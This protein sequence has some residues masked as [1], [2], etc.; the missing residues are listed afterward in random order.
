MS[1]YLN[2]GISTSIAIWIIVILVVVVGGGILV[3]QYYYIAEKGQPDIQTLTT[4]VPIISSEDKLTPEE[5]SQRLSECKNIQDYPDQNVCYGN[6][7]IDA[8]D[9]SICPEFCSSVCRYF[10]FMWYTDLCSDISIKKPIFAFGYDENRATRQDLYKKQ[11]CIRKIAID[12]KN[13][14]LCRKLF[15]QI[16]DC[17]NTIAI[18]LNDP[19]K[20]LDSYG[21]S[22]G[23]CIM[24]IAINKKDIT[25]CE[26]KYDKA[27]CIAIFPKLLQESSYRENQGCYIPPIDPGL[28]Q[29]LLGGEQSK[30]YSYPNTYDNGVNDYPKDIAPESA[31]H[32]IQSIP[33]NVSNAIL[34]VYNGSGDA[35]IRLIKYSPSNN[36]SELV[37]DI[38]SISGGNS[39]GIYIPIAIF[40]D[41]S[42]ILFKGKMG[43]PG[44]GGGTDTMGYAYLSLAS[45][46][47]DDC[48]YLSLEGISADIAYFYDNFSKALFY[49]E[50]KNVPPSERPGYYYNS[51]IN[52]INIMTT[53]SKI[54]LEEPNTIYEI[55]NVDE[56]SGVVNFKSCPWQ[57]YRFS[58][59]PISDGSTRSRYINLP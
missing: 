51:A 10:I 49:S 38:R 5:F 16:P 43:A 55:I 4:E 35:F 47:Y 33:F 27:W 46:E 17:K 59:C 39:G 26:S 34:R 18:E 29:G 32:H 54:L 8:N 57:K 28:R 14:E 23:Y 21:Y 2:R 45:V 53:E 58:S 42:H 20:C 37:G 50:E 25:I 9:P 44:A 48:G 41:D 6:L 13:I 24:K 19:S 22:D 52:F 12:T 56:E 31:F 15:N 7:A 40:K 30:A 36:S 11:E 1:K 3:Y